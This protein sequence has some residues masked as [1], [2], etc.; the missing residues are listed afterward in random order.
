MARIFQLF[1]FAGQMT[2]VEFLPRA[3]GFAAFFALLWGIEQTG[4]LAPDYARSGELVL[5][6]IIL[7][8]VPILAMMTRRLA[9]SGFPLGLIFAAPICLGLASA[10]TVMFGWDA[11]QT[12]F[13]WAAY[14]AFA[15][16]LAGLL[17]PSRFTSSTPAQELRQ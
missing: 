14:P 2:L 11:G 17:W 5:F 6:G 13:T 15:A 12:I 9:D 4:L 10:S 3:A 7:A 16:L 1:N 8:T